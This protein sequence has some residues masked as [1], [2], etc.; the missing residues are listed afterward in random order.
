MCTVTKS[1]VHIH[2]S[3]VENIRVAWATRVAIKIFET[4]AAWF[5]KRIGSFFEIQ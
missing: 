2:I 5:G 3:S 1:I 4:S